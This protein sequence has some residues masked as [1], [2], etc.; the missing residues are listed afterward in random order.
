MR[1]MWTDVKNS[2]HFYSQHTQVIDHSLTFEANLIEP[3]HGERCRSG[4]R[5]T[6]WGIDK[7]GEP[8][9]GDEWEI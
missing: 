5:T 6:G 9:A 8:F 3:A 4:E 7:G 2:M 1:P